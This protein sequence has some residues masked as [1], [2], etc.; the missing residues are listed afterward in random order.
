[1]RLSELKERGKELNRQSW[2]R[3]EVMK[4]IAQIVDYGFKRNVLPIPQITGAFNPKTET[5]YF[6]LNPT[7][8]SE[9]MK[10]VSY[11]KIFDNQEE[12]NIVYFRVGKEHDFSKREDVIAVEFL[13]A[14]YDLEEIINYYKN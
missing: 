7:V 5:N 1:M 2:D 6:R 14:D 9:K 8:D 12:P 10:Y 13:Y 3:E 4:F 11:Y